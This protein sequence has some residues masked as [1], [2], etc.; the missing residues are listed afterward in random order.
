MKKIILIGSEGVLGSY[1]AKNLVKFNKILVVADI[2]IQKNSRIG[3]LVKRKLNIENEEEVKS[4]FLR[5]FTAIWKI[6]YFDK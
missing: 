2:K 6:R 4:F 5:N 3:K 1:Y